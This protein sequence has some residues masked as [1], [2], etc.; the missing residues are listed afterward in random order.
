MVGWQTGTVPSNTVDRITIGLIVRSF[1]YQVLCCYTQDNI[2]RLFVFVKK[3]TSTNAADGRER[4]SLDT[5]IRRAVLCEL[6]AT[7]EGE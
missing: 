4:S 5:S 3:T 1:A 6:R 2:I 7:G